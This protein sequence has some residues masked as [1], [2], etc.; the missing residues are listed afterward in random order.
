MNRFFLEP[1][2]WGQTPIQLNPRESHH[3]SKVLRHRV[4]EQVEV[5]DGQGKYTIAHLQHIKKK[6]VELTLESPKTSPRIPAEITLAQAIPKGKNM[7]LIIQKSVELGAAY[8]Q[9]LLSEHTVIQLDSQEIKKKLEKWS[10]IL[11]DAC[12]QSGQNWLPRLL[13]ILHLSD[14]LKN[15]KSD[16]AALFMGSLGSN[17]IPFKSALLP[18][19]TNHPDDKFFKATLLV[20]PEGDFSPNERQAA[21][22]A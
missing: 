18:K 22:Q 6:T 7:D 20:G 11:L 4:G 19:I 13:P 14:Y 1:N 15:I 8:I 5:F 9:P 21:A 10:D 12:K 17:A 2:A 3:C 16:S